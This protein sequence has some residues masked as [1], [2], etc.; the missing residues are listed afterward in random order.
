[1]KRTYDQ[2]INHVALPGEGY[3]WINLFDTK[4][5]PN[6][7][8]WPTA[9][10]LWRVGA[11]DTWLTIV[12]VVEGGI[13]CHVSES[14][15]DIQLYDIDFPELYFIGGRRTMMPEVAQ[16]LRRETQRKSG[17][18]ETVRRPRR[19]RR[20]R[21]SK[22]S[23]EPT[24][25]ARKFVSRRLRM[26][27]VKR[28][29]H[30]YISTAVALSVFAPDLDSESYFFALDEFSY[31]ADSNFQRNA[32]LPMESKHVYYGQALCRPGDKIPVRWYDKT[33]YKRLHAYE[34]KEDGSY[35]EPL[36]PYTVTEEKPRFWRTV[37]PTKV[38]TFFR[39]EELPKVKRPGRPGPSHRRVQDLCELQIPMDMF[40]GWY[41]FDMANFRRLRLE[42]NKPKR[43]I[44]TY[45]FG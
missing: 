11:K 5:T 1:M 34:F 8:P 10:E 22:G 13:F 28:Y 33:F 30:V 6:L 3:C 31:V 45:S 24:P 19:S 14:E 7:G 27:H 37:R 20:E 40:S 29:I 25:R 17:E 16:R 39:L 12:T 18:V 38:D 42:R 43:K 21:F 32:R 15:S 26:A 44:W 23:S 35:V 4:K 41:D 2:M 36:P 9:L